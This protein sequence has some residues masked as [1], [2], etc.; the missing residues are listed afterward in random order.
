MRA[1]TSLLIC[2]DEALQ[3]ILGNRGKCAFD[4]RGNKRQILRGTRGQRQYWGTGNIRKQIFNLGG[5]GEQAYLLQ[6]NKG[7]CTPPGEGLNDLF[8]LWLKSAWV[9]HPHDFARM[10]DK[11]DDSVVL[12]QLQVSSLWEMTTRD[13]VHSV[14]HSP[15]FKILLQTE[16]RTSSIV[17]SPPSLTNSARMILTSADFAIFSAFTTAST[18]S[19]RIGIGRGSSSGICWQSSTIGSWLYKS[20]K[21][22]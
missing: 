17:A 13:L 3:G 9:D 6:G 7:T 11:A 19:H 10:A 4:V 16:V 12:A 22:L 15:V 20:Q 2:N 1:E 18:S 21:C 8:R 14:G 5:T